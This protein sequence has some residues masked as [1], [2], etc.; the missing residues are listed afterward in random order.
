VGDERGLFRG[1]ELEDAVR[2]N[3]HAAM[4]ARSR[5]EVGALRLGADM[6]SDRLHKPADIWVVASDGT[7]EKRRIHDR[8]PSARARV[9][10][11]AF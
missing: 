7:F 11:A 6:F 1:I 4:R 5:E 2:K 10:L 8:L 9:G 3:F